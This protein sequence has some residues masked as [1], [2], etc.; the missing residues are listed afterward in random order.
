M[1]KQKTRSK[2]DATKETGDW[3]LI[4]EDKKTE[5]IGYEQIE[6]EIRIV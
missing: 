6:S 1:A 5:F 3:I 2:S 4:D